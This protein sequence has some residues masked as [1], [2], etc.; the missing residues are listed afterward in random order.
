MACQ[1]FK[2][3]HKNDQHNEQKIVDKFNSMNKNK[4]TTIY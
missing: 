2:K 3:Y 4:S 1:W